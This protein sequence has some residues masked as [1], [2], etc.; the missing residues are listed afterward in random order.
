MS[1]ENHSISFIRLLSFPFL[2]IRA[3]CLLH[4]GSAPHVRDL[5]RAAI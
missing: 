1:R 2:R 5:K 4:V 3:S